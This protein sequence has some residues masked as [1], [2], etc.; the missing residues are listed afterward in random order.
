MLKIP[1]EESALTPIEKELKKS[2]GFVQNLATAAALDVI[3]ARLAEVEL[4]LELYEDDEDH[5]PIIRIIKQDKL[6]LEEAL[7]DLANLK[8][9]DGISA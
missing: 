2:F 9:A 4:A 3:L 5:K 8:E 6:E 1:K 7:V